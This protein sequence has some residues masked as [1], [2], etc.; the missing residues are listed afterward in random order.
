MCLRQ[1]KRVAA[2]LVR[3][4]RS[5]LG[6]RLRRFLA[7]TSDPS[8]TRAPAHASPSQSRADEANSGAETR[9]TRMSPKSESESESESEELED[10]PSYDM[11]T[12][13]ACQWCTWVQAGAKGARGPCQVHSGSDAVVLQGGCVRG[14]A[15]CFPL[16][17]AHPLEG[18]PEPTSPGGVSERELG[19]AQGQKGGHT[20]QSMTPSQSLPPHTFVLVTNLQKEAELW[21]YLAGCKPPR[22]E[23]EAKAQSEGQPSTPGNAKAGQAPGDSAEASVKGQRSASKG[24][25]GSVLEEAKDVTWMAE[26]LPPLQVSTWCSRAVARAS[27]ASDE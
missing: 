6:P 16:Q 26:P 12:G 24:Q 10:V 5:R 20:P 17:G 18:S 15:H 21:V 23:P 7:Q 27:H 11:S 1:Q 3:Q 25:R 2:P 19:G 22:L 4:L 8:R 14:T 9:P 13:G